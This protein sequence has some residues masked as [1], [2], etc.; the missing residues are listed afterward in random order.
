MLVSAVAREPAE[1]PVGE[2]FRGLY[3]DER[4]AT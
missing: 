3:M 4:D 1:C 2:P